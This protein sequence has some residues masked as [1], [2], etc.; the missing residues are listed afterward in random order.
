MENVRIQDD[1]YTYVNQAKLEICDKIHQKQ[2]N[3]LSNDQIQPVQLAKHDAVGIQEKYI[4]QNS[5]NSHQNIFAHIHIHSVGIC[6]SPHKIIQQRHNDNFQQCLRRPDKS[7]GILICTSAHFPHEV[8][9]I[10]F[11]T[12]ISVCTSITMCILSLIIIDCTISKARFQ[13]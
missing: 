6:I 1:L 3:K 12:V 7:L 11:S 4:Q 8:P 5:V 13:V 9:H 10:L 2:C